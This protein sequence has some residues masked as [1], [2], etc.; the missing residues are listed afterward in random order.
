V[1]VGCE[2]AS[3]RREMHRASIACQSVGLIIGCRSFANVVMAAAS[4]C[5]PAWVRG[6]QSNPRALPEAANGRDA[7]PRM[8]TIQWFGHSS[9][10]ITAPEGTAGATDPH[11]RHKSP[12]APEI[13]TIRND[14]PTHYHASSVPGS[15][16]VLLGRTAD[17]DCIE[18]NI[19]SAGLG[20]AILVE[21]SLSFLGMGVPPPALSW[22]RMPSAEG[23]WFFETAFWMA[24]FPGAF[25]I[26]TATVFG[27]NLFGDPLRDVLD[28][29]RNYADVRERS[30]DM[31]DLT[32]PSSSLA[33]C[34]VRVS[35]L[36][37]VP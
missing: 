14:H 37:I 30:P 27:A 28:P 13:A 24:I 17:G 4:L 1:T 25:I 35:T 9:F 19:A 8:A 6:P 12:I 21:A 23:M 18:V 36:L 22:G 34:T 15:A 29:G 26:A 3:P 33:H 11:P 20:G 7:T 32:G 31:A 16:R 2:D 10:L 5:M